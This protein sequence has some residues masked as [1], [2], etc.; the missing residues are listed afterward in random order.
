MRIG[1]LAAR[2]GVSVRALRYYEE[3]HLLAPARS[4]SGQR[5]YRSDDVDR[6]RLIRLLLG[7]G[8]T[9]DAIRPI[10]P[11]VATGVAT[12]EMLDR[13]AAERARIDRQIR[14][15]AETRDRLDTVIAMGH[16]H[17]HHENLEHAPC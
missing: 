3:Q 16:E 17:P 4:G 15:L 13:L 9:S 2:T 5:H 10:M 7:A 1:D 14:D 8:L 11:C 6:V 12:P